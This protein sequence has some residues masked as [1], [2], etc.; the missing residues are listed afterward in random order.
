MNMPFG[1]VVMA[2]DALLD[3]ICP[4]QQKIQSFY[5]MKCYK[6]IQLLL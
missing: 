6:S 5:V 2:L 3:G 4:C 1:P